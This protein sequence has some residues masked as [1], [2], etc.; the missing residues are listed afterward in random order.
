[1][2]HSINFNL[3]KVTEVEQFTIEIQKRTETGST[4]NNRFRK[5]GFIPSIMYHRHEP[6]LPVLLPQKE[7]ILLAKQAK[8]SQVFTCKS[9]DKELDGKAVIVKE[10]QKDYVGN[11]LLH[12]D[13]QILKDDEEITVHVP[14]TFVGEAPGV[15]LDGGILTVVAHDIAVSCLP[16]AIPAFIEVDVSGVHLGK[17]IH[18]NELK[19]PPNVKLGGNEDETIVSV[20]AVRQV[21]EEAAPAAA[22]TPEAAAA[23][24][25]APAEG[26]A[27]PTEGEKEKPKK[28]K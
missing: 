1:M 18:A 7:F 24:A 27:A 6:S 11:K 12:V 25:A 9:K 22:A 26:A 5:A 10:I 23:A 8:I 21:V 4:A 2:A 16:K 28:E 20:V 3:S 13:L 17:S 15:K 19:L 14:L